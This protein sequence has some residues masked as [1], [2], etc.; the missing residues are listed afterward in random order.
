[1]RADDAPDEREDS[2]NDDG[3]IR[4]ENGH[5]GAGL[6]GAMGAASAEV[7]NLIAD[8]EDLLRGVSNVG[9][10]DVARLRARVGATV[11]EAKAALLE[12]TADLRT[13]AS[14]AAA[15]ADDYVHERPWAAI[16]IAAA[17]G[18]AIGLLA[19]RRRGGDYDY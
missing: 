18:L 3:T 14:D 10:A 17:V 8:V 2:M 7:R 6:G 12:G 15:V 16:G 13:Q 9:D 5:G 1:M 19:G 4:K 11:A